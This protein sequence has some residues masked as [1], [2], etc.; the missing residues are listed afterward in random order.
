[1]NRILCLWLPNWPVQRRVGEKPELDDQPLVLHATRMGKTMVTACSDAAAAKGVAP[2]MPLAEARA[3]WPA[4][5]PRVWIRP[6][7]PEADRRALVGWAYFAQRYSPRVTLEDAEQP[8]CLLLD[9]TGC[10]H[11]FGGEKTL[12]ETVMHDLRCRGLAA[13]IAAADTVGAAWAF[14]HIAGSGPVIVPA[15]KH[16]KLLGGLDLSLLRISRDTVSQFQEFDIR[17][18]AQLM[19][20]P[21]AEVV[22]RF[23]RDVL[24]RLDQALGD[25]PEVVRP[26]QFVEP[27]AAFWEF[28]DATDQR[29]A[30]AKVIEHLLQGMLDRIAPEQLGI[31]RLTCE[32]RT[33]NKEKVSLTVGLLRP[34]DSL[35]YLMELAGLQ[36]ENLRLPA[37]VDQATLH[38]VVAPRSWRQGRIFEADRPDTRDEFHA[39]LERLSS[40]VGEKSVLRACLRPEAQP[41]L[42]W[43]YVPW[44]GSHITDRSCTLSRGLSRPLDLR[45][46]PAPVR[47]EMAGGPARFVWRERPYVVARSWGPERIETGWW[48]GRDIRR[49]YYRVEVEGG[50]R[51]WL[52]RDLVRGSWYLHGVYG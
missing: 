10:G 37:E 17:S 18:I 44:L 19:N 11:L 5:D 6:H 28:E 33:T 42:S 27:V 15:D 23:G 34:C 26:E 45:G 32:L 24:L 38:A 43:D 40:R 16:R 25:V 2:G 8:D 13:R 49:D 39:L 48:R 36:L 31:E 35:R 21:R 29:W 22:I 46:S 47:V 9:I 51:F 4:S 1:M 14:S 30:L 7:D 12:A 20:L 52:F 3:L 41:E 50:Q